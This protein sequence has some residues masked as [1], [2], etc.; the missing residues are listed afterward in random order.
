MEVERRRL[1]LDLKIKMAAIFRPKSHSTNQKPLGS[2]SMIE[3]QKKNNSCA[4]GSS[5]KGREMEWEKACRRIELAGNR[6]AV[7]WGR[8]RHQAH[9]SRKDDLASCLDSQI[10]SVF[11]LLH[12]RIPS[13]WI[14]GETVAQHLY[15][16]ENKRIPV[17]SITFWLVPPAPYAG[18]PPAHSCRVYAWIY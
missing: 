17:C 9:L 16:D 11:A 5:R 14:L 8:S 10:Q 13:N 18:S 2:F 3:D 1:F 15:L 12:P 4:S 6:A 7:K